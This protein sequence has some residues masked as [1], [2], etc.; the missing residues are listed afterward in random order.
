MLS[1]HFA[2]DLHPRS[3]SAPITL[4]TS[5]HIKWNHDPHPQYPLY[6]ATLDLLGARCTHS[7]LLPQQTIHMG[8]GDVSYKIHEREREKIALF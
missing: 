3:T 6:S 2:I 1:L 4:T 8:H 7:R 5:K